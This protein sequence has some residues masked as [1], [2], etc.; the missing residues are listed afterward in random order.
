MSDAAHQQ[1]PIAAAQERPRL[2]FERAIAAVSRLYPQLARADVDLLVTLGIFSG[3]GLLSS[4]L[5]LILDHQLNGQ[6]PTL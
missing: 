3:V 5:L 4:L 6:L 1:E 2:W